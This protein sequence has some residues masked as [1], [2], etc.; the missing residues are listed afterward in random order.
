MEHYFPDYH[1]GRRQSRKKNKSV[2]KKTLF[3]RGEKIFL[4]KDVPNDARSL[5]KIGCKK[6]L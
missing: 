4:T 6:R 1:K 3:L 2:L 5:K